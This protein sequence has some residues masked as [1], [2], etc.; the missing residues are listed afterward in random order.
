MSLEHVYIDITHSDTISIY[1]SREHILNA[2]MIDTK[3]HSGP[4]RRFHSHVVTHW[5]FILGRNLIAYWLRRFPSRSLPKPAT[6]KPTKQKTTS[7]RFAWGWLKLSLPTKQKTDSWN[8]IGRK[9]YG[10]TQKF[11]LSLSHKHTQTC[12]HTHSLCHTYAP[13]Q[14]QH[15]QSPM[16]QHMTDHQ[17]TM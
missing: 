7:R 1:I 10:H 3:L 5:H 12:T 16:Q 9:G 13:T 2:G 6:I 15:I 14:A 4:I 11:I 17:V 8:V